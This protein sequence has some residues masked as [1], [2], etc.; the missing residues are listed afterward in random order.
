MIG[1]YTATNPIPTPRLLT[2]SPDDVQVGDDEGP[3]VVDVIVQDVNDLAAFEFSVTYDPAVVHVAG[4]NLGGFLGS[5]GRS[6]APLGP[7]IDNTSGQVAF[8]AFS[9]GAGG[10]ASGTGALAVITFTLQATGTTPLAFENPQLLDTLNYEI[11]TSPQ[12]GQIQVVRYPFGDLDHD[13]VVDITD[14]M[15]VASRWNSR[16]GDPEYDPAY[17]FDGDNDIDV[18]DVMQVAAAWGDTCQGVTMA[19]GVSAALPAQDGPD[20]LFDPSGA[21]VEVGAPFTMSVVISGVVDLGGFE[22]DLLFDPAAVTVTNVHLGSFLGSSNN[23]AVPLGPRVVEYGRVIFGAFSYGENE[24]PR[25]AGGLATVDLML[26]HDQD[27][28]LHL[29]DVQLVTSAAAE[30]APNAVGTGDIYALHEGE[31][32]VPLILR[33]W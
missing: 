9:Y 14:I 27:T 22:F 25:G 1:A 23:Q 19:C 17:D 26:L 11:P 31:I 8:G 21:E 18:A 3:L 13:C 12:G 16:L 29:D 7:D 33:H 20:V 30:I 24:G 15:V 32:F 4:V 6:T 10:G 2:F 5:G 28:F